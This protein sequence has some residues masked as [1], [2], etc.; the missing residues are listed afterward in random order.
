MAGA[1]A[2]QRDL[3]WEVSIERPSRDT[4]A[5][6]DGE[7]GGVSRADRRVQIDRGLDDLPPRRDLIFCPLFQRVSSGDFRELLCDS[8]IDS[9][10]RAC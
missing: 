7:V 4:C 3:V 1:G 6:G 9:R 2:K 5:L 10:C 8:I